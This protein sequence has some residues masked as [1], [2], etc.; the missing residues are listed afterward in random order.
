MASDPA[1]A[2]AAAD[3]AAPRPSIT[4]DRLPPISTVATRVSLTAQNI[5]AGNTGTGTSGSQTNTQQ[6]PQQ[7]QQHSQY[8]RNIA[9]HLPSS[10]HTSR[11]ICQ[12]QQIQLE[13]LQSET[14][15]Q[16]SSTTTSTNGGAS[17]TTNAYPSRRRDHR[18]VA[19][20]RTSREQDYQ[21]AKGA[22]RKNVT[23][24]TVKKQLNFGFLQNLTPAEIEAGNSSTTSTPVFDEK[25]MKR[26][27]AVHGMRL[28]NGPKE[29]RFDSITALTCK[30]LHADICTIT[31]VDSSMVR[32]WSISDST[33]GKYFSF[34][35]T[36]DPSI[37]QEARCDS[38]CQYTIREGTG[39][40]GNSTV[41][42]GGMGGS[43]GNTVGEGK[44]GFVVLDASREPKFKSRPL[45]QSG[46]HFYAGAPLITRSGVKIGALS[47]RGP[48]RSQ[49]TSQEAKLLRQ[50]TEWA[51]DEFELYVAK[52][53]LDFRELLRLAKDQMSELKE[54]VCSSGGRWTCGRGVL[55]N[56]IDIIKNALKLKNVMI[57]KIKK[58][59]EGARAIRSTVFA[60][61]EKCEIKPGDEKFTELCQATLDKTGPGP[62]ILDRSHSVAS[63]LQVCRYIG[64]HVRQSAS[65]LIWSHG[66]PVGVI[67]LFFEGTYKTVSPLEEQF[68]IS[69]AIIVST[70]W[71]QMETH[72]SLSKSMNPSAHSQLLANKLKQ[73]SAAA[74]NASKAKALAAAAAA[75][76]TTVTAG[77]GASKLQKTPIYKSNFSLSSHHN[78]PTATRSKIASQSLL[79][80][81]QSQT[82]LS[83]STGT[84]S[85]PNSHFS[86]AAATAAA[87]TAAAVPPPPMGLPICVLI[88][89]PLLPPIKGNLVSEATAKSANLQHAAFNAT[90]NSSMSNSSNNNMS[91][92]GECVGISGGGGGA[93]TTTTAGATSGGNLTG[94]S[95]SN[96]NIYLNSL[97]GNSG[98]YSLF[99]STR[100]LKS[101]SQDHVGVGSGGGG[102]VKRGGSHSSRSSSVKPDGGVRNS[103]SHNGGGGGH[104]RFKSTASS[105]KSGTDEVRRGRVGSA[106]EEGMGI[107]GGTTAKSSL[108]PKGAIDLLADFTQMME[109][110]GEQQGIK[111][112]KKC[113]SLFVAITGLMDD[114]LHCDSLITLARNLS[115]T[116][117]EY[118]GETGIDVSARIGVHGALIPFEIGDNVEVVEN[119]WTSLINFT[120]HLECHS[121]STITISEYIQRNSVLLRSNSFIQK[122]TAYISGYGAAKI[123]IVPNLDTNHHHNSNQ[124]SIGTNGHQDSRT[125][126]NSMDDDDRGGGARKRTSVDSGGGRW[127]FTFRQKRKQVAPLPSLSSRSNQQHAISA[128]T[129]EDISADKR[130]NDDRQCNIM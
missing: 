22:S 11:F 108:T 74:I 122:Q 26:V 12:T 102:G 130:R 104:R 69:S 17:N 60:L 44:D 113:G 88:C 105:V 40:S 125:T 30:L 51:I 20:A 21:Q 19:S 123:Y 10:H 112:V 33:N 87:A 70:I 13:Q 89:E 101:K 90:T 14:S 128:F 27:M 62:Y 92:N 9:S 2:A 78:L 32:Y 110:V 83:K 54:T 121:D 72:D 41:R 119:A 66:R 77:L 59:P 95:S 5:V 35:A 85:S 42:G 23:L 47:I 79:T 96:S 93:A 86:P 7:Q 28:W 98:H 49:F 25:E 4:A 45:V 120:Y 34:N 15:S 80:L 117:D 52:R 75:A 6:Q 109:V 76:A 63:Q 115:Q 39:A 107:W 68:L 82:S 43:S 106:I 37:I 114:K 18:R 103:L 67:A 94:N 111:Y 36:Q 58:N 73:A 61:A 64:E 127:S 129:D 55:K 38:F 71:Q 81:H 116:L 100:S 50:M 8:E 46:L 16:T 48:A 118:A 91:S 1:A 84:L 53:E 97:F 65:E 3:V 124:I 29:P 24:N 126:L 31:I 57:L 99:G 56:C